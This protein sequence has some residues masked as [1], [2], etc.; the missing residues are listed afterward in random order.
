MKFL[1]GDTSLFP[2]DVFTL[3]QRRHGAVLLHFFGLIYMFIALSVV[4]DEYFVPSLSVL[5][6]KVIIW[7]LC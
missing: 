7:L 5:T 4:C 3:E 1:D 2:R 6:E